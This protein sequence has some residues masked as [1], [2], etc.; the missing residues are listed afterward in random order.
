MR[1]YYISIGIAEIQNTTNQMLWRC[2]EE[3]SSLV[4]C[5]MVRSLWKTVWQILTE[6][7]IV[8]PYNLAVMFLGTYPDDLKTYV[9]TETCTLMLLAPLFITVKNWSNQE[10]RWM[11]NKNCYIHKMEHYWMMKRNVGSSHKKGRMEHRRFLGQWNYSI[12]Y[13]N[14]GCMTL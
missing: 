8:L 5:K 13:Y 12:W 11:Y 9:H 10:N 2:E 4:G 3:L 1:Y 14:G 6:L 7:N